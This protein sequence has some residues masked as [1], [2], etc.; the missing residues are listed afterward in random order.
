MGMRSRI[1]FGKYIEGSSWVHRL[2]PRAKTASMLLF[3]AAV[4][5]T[6]SY[7]SI[8]A[9]LLFAAVVIMST[10][11]P[12]AMFARAIKPLLFIIVFIFLFHVLFETSGQS[13]IDLGPFTLYA[14]GLER[15]IVSASRMILFIA[16]AAI[17]TF[18]TRPESL[19]Q[20][21]GSLLM[22]LRFIGLSPGKIALMVGIALRFI[23]TVFEEAERIWKAQ[24]ARGLNLSEKPLVKRAM[25]L[26]SLLVPVLAGSFRRAVDLADSMEARGYRLG[27]GRTSYRALQW[28]SRDTLFLL[29]FALPVTAGILL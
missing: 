15:G 10:R 19:V 17:L 14:G 28:S 24:L 11:I 18:T 8:L 2:D 21:L 26:L 6:D 25:L 27:V 4:F 22:P 5:V 20:G 16:F 23:P 12:L 7:A 3:M 13:F 1:V 9:L 29:S